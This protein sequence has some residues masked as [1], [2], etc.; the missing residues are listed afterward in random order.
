MVAGCRD[1]AVSPTAAAADWY[2]CTNMVASTRNGTRPRGAARREALLD[3]VLRVVAEVGVDAVTHRR[4]AEVAGL[5]LAST[6]YW[7]E[8][9]EQM[10][11]AALER[12]AD[13]DI[14]RLRAFVAE[15]ASVARDPLALAVSA[16]LGPSE[17]AK[18]PP[19]GAAAK[20]PI[21][22]PPSGAGANNPIPTSRGWL[23]ATYTL[24]LE[25]ARRPALREV[26]TRWTDAYLEAIPPL[27]A[28]AGS[29]RPRADAE[30]LLA[31]TD[32][33]IVDQLATG[34]VSD[35]APRLRRLAKALVKA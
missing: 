33:L 11:T 7:F 29:K 26:T 14:E 23:L 15:N 21:P 18:A 1:P 27:L 16:I 35:P 6:T 32:G 10:L 30:I 24:M 5:P 12:A 34:D 28:S 25:A 9:K 19:S 13:R 31:A 3:A 20:N 2:I 17:E 8:S 22:A 4:V